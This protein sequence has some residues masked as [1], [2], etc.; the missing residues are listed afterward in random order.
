MGL[1]DS[2]DNSESIG[3]NLN[4]ISADQ[5]KKVLIF[6]VIGVFEIV[7]FIAD[8]ITQNG[9]EYSDKT[10]FIGAVLSATFIFLYIRNLFLR[11]KN[12]SIAI[13][14]YASLC[15]ISFLLAQFMPS[16][17]G[18]GI[19]LYTFNLFNISF[20]RTFSI[21]FDIGILS[22]LNPLVFLIACTVFHKKYIK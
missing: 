22:T 14:S 7:F 21:N 10:E 9:Y 12:I 11:K 15:V 6:F 19:F 2:N 17:N 20:W 13:I 5:I 8:S 3:N 16:S 4:S 18:L 1:Y